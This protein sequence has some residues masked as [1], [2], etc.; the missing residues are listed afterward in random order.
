MRLGWPKLV[1]PLDISLNFFNSPFYMSFIFEIL[2]QCTHK[3]FE[4][5]FSNQNLQE[6][7][8]IPFIFLLL[9]EFILNPLA[10]FTFL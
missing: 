2:R 4:F 7:Q 8:Q 3:A 6:S 9:V 1:L 5:H 10:A